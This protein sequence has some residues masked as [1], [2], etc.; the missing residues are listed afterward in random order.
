[1][2]EKEININ[3]TATSQ[4][5]ILQFKDIRTQAMRIKML[6]KKGDFEEGC[7]IPKYIGRPCSISVVLSSLI[8]LSA[9]KVNFKLTVQ[10]Q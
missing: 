10:G 5:A 8:W 6:N 1:M 9:E 3:L 7:E 2:V 4:N